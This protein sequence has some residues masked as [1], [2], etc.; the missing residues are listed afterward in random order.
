MSW[1]FWFVY[2]SLLATKVALILSVIEIYDHPLSIMIFNLIVALTGIILKLSVSIHHD[3]SH[4]SARQHFV[5]GLSNGAMMDIWDTASLLTYTGS[6][7]DLATTAL[8]IG[9]EYDMYNSTND[10][11]SSDSAGSEWEWVIAWDWPTLKLPMT[12][13]V[14]IS[15]NLV[16]PT[17]PLLVLSRTR[18]GRDKMTRGFRVLQKL[19]YRFAVSMPLL[20]YRLQTFKGGG[21]SVFLFKNL[22][23]KN[24]SY[25]RGI[26]TGQNIFKSSSF[27]QF[28]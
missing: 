24:H 18:F 26:K 9:N 20:V 25:P 11:N 17:V 6:L 3:V 10:H 19:L 21:V 8:P 27:T 16:L 12:A 15:I 2:S 4:G 5:K 1:I 22:L 28:H 23:G 13:I 14:I 7:S